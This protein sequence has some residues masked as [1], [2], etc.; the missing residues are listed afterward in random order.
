MAMMNTMNVISLQNE[1]T[2]ANVG[3]LTIRRSALVLQPF[4]LTGSKQN[5][6]I[7]SRNMH[8][9]RHLITFEYYV[10]RKYNID[11]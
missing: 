5:I 9:D 10:I 6:K 8:Q 2:Y 4:N 7:H 3:K 11:I 1:N